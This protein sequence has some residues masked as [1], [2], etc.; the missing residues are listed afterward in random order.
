MNHPE[1]QAVIVLPLIYLDG[2][3]FGSRGDSEKTDLCPYAEP[4]FELTAVAPDEL[5]S[6]YGIE[7][8]QAGNTFYV[9]EWLIQWMLPGV[10]LEII[11][12]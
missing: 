4:V 9:P 5:S 7:T 1:R 2:E 10:E 6:L 11:Y 8:V 3:A 12:P